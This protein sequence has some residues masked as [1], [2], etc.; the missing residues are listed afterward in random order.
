M[1][2]LHGQRPAAP[3]DHG[4][5]GRPTSPPKNTSNSGTSAADRAFHT[6]PPG[7]DMSLPWS[8]GEYRN[9]LRLNE[10]PLVLQGFAR[11]KPEKLRYL[12]QQI[13]ND[14]H[15][16][17]HWAA[18]FP[19][20]VEV[21]QWCIE[22]LHC[23]PA[24]VAVETKQT[25]LMWAITKVDPVRDS[26]E[27]AT[28]RNTTTVFY[29][30]RYLIQKGGKSVLR[31][32]DSL[33]ASA[34]IIAVQHGNLPGF[35][36]C[37]GQDIHCVD[38]TDAHQC[39]AAHWCSF[40][41]ESL[42]VKILIRLYGAKLFKRR[43]VQQMTPLHRS[44][45]GGRYDIAKIL[46]QENVVDYEAKSRSEETAF[47]IAARTDDYMMKLLRK[48]IDRLDD[49]KRMS[50]FGTGKAVLMSNWRRFKLAMQERCGVVLL[51]TSR[52]REDR[53]SSKGGSSFE[54]E[55]TNHVDQNNANNSER[56]SEKDSKDGRCR[57]RMK[58]KQEDDPFG[59]P[60]PKPSKETRAA[61]N[62]IEQGD[63][64]FASSAAASSLVSSA[65]AGRFAFLAP[66]ALRAAGVLRKTEAG[67]K[68][69]AKCGE[70]Y[71]KLYPPNPDA[72]LEAMLSQKMPLRKPR[73]KF[74]ELF[75]PA[76]VLFLSFL[77]IYWSRYQFCNVWGLPEENLCPGRTVG[78]SAGVAELDSA[79]AAPAA[80]TSP[81]ISLHTTSILTADSR[82]DIIAS[83]D[84]ETTSFLLNPATIVTLPL[85][86]LAR[87]LSNF[88]VAK[89]SSFLWW[90]VFGDVTNPTF[91]HSLMVLLDWIFL[92][93][94]FKAWLSNPGAVKA[95]KNEKDQRTMICNYLAETH[96]LEKINLLTHFRLCETCFC[97]RDFRTKHCRV[98]GVCVHDFDHYCPWI[99]NAVG[100]GNHRSFMAF[101]TT[102][103]V[104]LGMMFIRFIE[105]FYSCWFYPERFG[106][107][108]ET[109][110]K[111]EWDRNSIPSTS[112][113][114]TRSLTFDAAL[115]LSTTAPG[116]PS[117]SGSAGQDVSF[118]IT[119][120][121]ADEVVAT[122]PIVPTTETGST[123]TPVEIVMPRRV[124]GQPSWFTR[125][126]VYW[127]VG[128]FYTVEDPS[129]ALQPIIV[130]SGATSAGGAVADV[131]GGAVLPGLG[132]GHAPAP[133][134][135]SQI[136]ITN[137]QQAPTSLTGKV[138]HFLLY[139][140]TDDH[141]F[142]GHCLVFL[143]DVVLFAW[144]I[145][146]TLFQL[147]VVMDNMTTNEQLSAHKYPHLWK[148]IMVKTTARAGTMGKKKCCAHDHGDHA[149][150]EEEEDICVDEELE[151]R[152]N[153][154]GPH[155][156]HPSHPPPQRPRMQPRRVF[157]N[158]YN[159]KGSVM[160]NCRDFWFTRHDP[161]VQ[162]DEPSNRLYRRILQQQGM[163][164]LTQA[165]TG[166]GLLA[167][168]LGSA[169]GATPSS[170]GTRARGIFATSNQGGQNNGGGDIEVD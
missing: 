27:D 157:S 13:D 20:E 53:S 149:H 97:I 7:D 18:L 123:T 102:L 54:T 127:T 112:S 144:L 135:T 14:G 15:N 28:G 68:V 105:F 114:T 138:I 131:V 44:V 40:R 162:Q 166:G 130:D 78:A 81:P 24:Q 152:M 83:I 118:P 39:T 129:K 89:V 82:P 51:G 137:T 116:A 36:L 164:E 66:I 11:E 167:S 21:L 74:T 25:P 55:M 90:V 69:L 70:V 119:A 67:R 80:T 30:L 58:E 34:L 61:K 6:R 75:I 87:C 72:I 122:T 134:S 120:P 140:A 161:V 60:S 139:H 148:T 103:M 110:L 35:L 159:D 106:I 86:A 99:G 88:S 142:L 117:P 104:S 32:R 160:N 46:L 165:V 145:G 42:M 85:F 16:L 22:R 77:K 163:L 63:S 94:Y 168:V 47:Q 1:V 125:F 109:F 10:M 9:L 124:W 79:S 37:L 169:T 113:S 26:V 19:E 108:F 48:E 170:S 146:L 84:A 107:D 151:N 57:R 95:F 100:R 147:K 156:H 128:W 143:I 12:G 43:D 71:L 91:F 56:I 136:V 115:A 4:A 52:G 111:D 73:L 50:W 31:M 96:H 153:G 62:A 3:R 5:A 101:V 158:A 141:N 41:G 59:S 8:F 17:L 121:A 76:I 38:D 154:Q 150:H 132:A 45:I 33:G 49:E 155:H 92:I 133:S 98:S 2:V 23:N 29:G 126:A 93:S 65:V 64:V